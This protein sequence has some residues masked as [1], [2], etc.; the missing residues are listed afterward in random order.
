MKLFISNWTNI[1]L[2]LLIMED[3]VI[4][5]WQAQEPHFHLNSTCSYKD[6]EREIPI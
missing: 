3:E 2:L 1:K 4:K 6:E 5:L